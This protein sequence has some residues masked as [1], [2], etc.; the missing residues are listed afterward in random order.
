MHCSVPFEQVPTEL[1]HWPP[2]SMG[3][4]STVPSQS[5]SLLLQVS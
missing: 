1:P 3:V 2:A 4:S 5:S